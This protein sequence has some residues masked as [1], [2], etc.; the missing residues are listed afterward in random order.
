MY[1]AVFED[2]SFTKVGESDFVASGKVNIG[3]IVKGEGST[4]SMKP[5]D[6]WFTE[7]NDS[8]ESGTKIIENGCA[9]NVS[10]VFID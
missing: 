4:A 3:L 9:V 5:Q 6:C 10:K 1:A 8:S 7:N 2:E